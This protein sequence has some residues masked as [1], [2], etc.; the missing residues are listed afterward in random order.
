MPELHEAVHEIV[1]QIVNASAVDDRRAEWAAYQE[2]VDL[3]ESSEREGCK[4]PFQWEALGDFTADRALAI[5]YYEKALGHAREASLDE[6]IASVCLAMAEALIDM[7]ELSRA[8]HAAWEASEAAAKTAD[9][10]LRT[11][12]SDLLLRLADGT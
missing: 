12:I 3:C 5:G 1:L 8:R 2:L 6:Y 7:G 11:S 4:H 10:E 9:I